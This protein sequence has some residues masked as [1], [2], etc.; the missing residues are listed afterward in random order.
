MVVIKESEIVKDV[1][2][3]NRHIGKILFFTDGFPVIVCGKGLLKIT[4]AN[5]EHDGKSIFPLNKFRVRF[6]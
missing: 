4:E 1:I 2:I 6:R 5:F 3:E